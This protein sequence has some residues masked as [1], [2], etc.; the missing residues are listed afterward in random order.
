MVFSGM[1]QRMEAFR[2][3]NDD[4][5]LREKFANVDVDIEEGKKENRSLGKIWLRTGIS[6]NNEL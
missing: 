1:A 6:T 2:M 3:W 5:Y 4:G